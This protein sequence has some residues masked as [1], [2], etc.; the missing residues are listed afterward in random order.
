MNCS[1]AR[2]KIIPYIKNQL[3]MN[4]IL[5]FIR[6]I[7]E[8]SDCKD[9]LEIYYILEH[10]LSDEEEEVSFDFTK[11]LNEQLEKEKNDIESEQT[12]LAYYQLVYDVASVV[13]LFSVG[14]FVIG[15]LL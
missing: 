3:S 15:Y 13:L 1:D 5:N 4:D 7:E 12:L 10:G 14:M 2:K 11:S 6:H 8:C 9:E